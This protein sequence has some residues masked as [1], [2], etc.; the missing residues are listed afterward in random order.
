[1]GF[2]DWQRDPGAGF[3]AG[4]AVFLEHFPLQG[5]FFWEAQ[6]CSSMQRCN[7]GKMQGQKLF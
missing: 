6:Q 3:A 4:C 1:M 2:M 7:D 5:G